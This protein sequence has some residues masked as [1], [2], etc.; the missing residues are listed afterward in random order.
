MQYIIFILYLS[1]LILTC[2]NQFHSDR[3]KQRLARIDIL[4]LLPVWTFFAPNPGV[5]DFNLLYRAKG[6]SGKISPF[7]N[8]P[9]NGDKNILN[10]VWNPRKRIQKAIGD[11]VQEIR[12]VVIS[13]EITAENQ[14]FLKLT[15]GYIV[16]LH[17]CANLSKSMEDIES[18]Q[19]SIIETFGHFEGREPRLVIN[20]DFHY[21]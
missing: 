13:E 11:F 1:W 4:R 16:I 19:F 9:L 20:S 14:H 6:K 21:L 10:A 3:V 7:H 15:F 5:S 2:F 17:Y 8:I 12:R 18:V